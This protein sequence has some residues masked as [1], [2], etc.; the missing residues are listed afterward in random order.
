MAVHLPL[1]AEARWEADN[2]MAAEKNLLKPA[3]GQPVITPKQDIVLGCFYLTKDD[4]KEPTTEPKIFSSEK[5][6]ILAYKSRVVALHEKVKVR[7]S[8][9]DKFT[10]EQGRIIET[11]VG[12]I[13]F[14]EVVPAK[15][16]YY[17]EVMNVK[18]LSKVI[19]LCLEIYGQEETA[20]FLDELKNVGFKYATKAG[21]SPGHER[22]S[23]NL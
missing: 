2:L 23:Q 15:L 5:E 9:L 1:T 6:A 12:R 20:R 18:K 17:N 14:N 22:L 10:A 7:F 21:Y 19:S 4:D 8:N 13:L 3:T 16:P 11:S